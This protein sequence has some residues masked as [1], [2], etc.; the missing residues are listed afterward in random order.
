MLGMKE[1][2][3][4]SIL[5]RRPVPMASGHEDKAKVIIHKDFK[6]YDPSLLEE[7]KDA[8]GCVWSL[9]VSQNSVNKTDY[10]DI[11]HD[12][13]MA[14]AEAFSTL[15]PDSP[16]TFVYVS[17]E[18]ATQ[19]PGMFT[20]LFGKVKGETETS[21][22]DF[23][24]KTPNFNVYNVRPGGVDWT[25]HP[26]IHDYMPQQAFYKRML[27]PGLNALASGIMTPTQPLGKILTQLAMS[28]GAPLKG[29][30]ILAEGRI[31]PNVAIRRMAGL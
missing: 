16:F 1:I 27:M 17:G 29:T 10:Y 2:T 12:Y 7:L 19:K 26:E 20:P 9:G 4:I 22:L 11:T 18:G 30:D 14:A 3:R 23:G 15:H 5:S 8:Q 25:K 6:K 28:K 13:T 21:L 31:V 24:N